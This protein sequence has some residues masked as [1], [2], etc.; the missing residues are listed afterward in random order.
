MIFVDMFLFPME[1]FH[2]QECTF[3]CTGQKIPFYEVNSVPISVN[4]RAG[5]VR[6]KNSA[7]CSKKKN[8]RVQAGLRNFMNSFLLGILLLEAMLKPFKGPLKVLFINTPQNMKSYVLY[9]SPDH[10]MTLMYV[11]TF[12]SENDLNFSER[13]PLYPFKCFCFFLII[14]KKN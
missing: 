4:Q 9:S 1:R 14:K 13:S 3:F 7:A 2:L 12:N 8:H 6:S 5:S 10:H 11:F